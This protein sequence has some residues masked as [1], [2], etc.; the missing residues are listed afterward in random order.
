MGLFLSRKRRA[1]PTG[2]GARMGRFVGSEVWT[3]SEVDC[4]D[5]S[6]F[7]PLL[8]LSKSTASNLGL[9]CMHLLSWMVLQLM[10]ICL[11]LFSSA[12]W[13]LLLPIIPACHHL[14]SICLFSHSLYFC[15]NALF[16]CF[17]NNSMLYKCPHA[18]PLNQ[19]PQQL[20]FHYIYCSHL[21][22]VII[23]KIHKTKDQ[24]KS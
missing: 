15:S 12:P 2:D 18:I 3:D 10:G 24:S 4:Q 14:S 23:E 21:L 16:E 5:A 17:Y 19:K 9:C 11:T 13:G 7:Q 22:V 8:C 1:T 6:F 20:Y